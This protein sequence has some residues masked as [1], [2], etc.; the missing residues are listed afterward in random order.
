MDSNCCWRSF[1]VPPPTLRRSYPSDLALLVDVPLRSGVCVVA[2]GAPKAIPDRNFADI[3]PLLTRDF[4]GFQARAPR[5]ISAAVL[6]LLSGT[7]RRTLRDHVFPGVRP[8]RMIDADHFLNLPTFCA[9]DGGFI[10][11][12]VEFVTRFRVAAFPAF[13]CFADDRHCGVPSR[14]ACNFSIFFASGSASSR[15]PPPWKSPLRSH[16]AER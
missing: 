2:A 1:I 10:G 14:R 4:A 3:C 15:N 13:R 16:S 5:R 12:R 7:G 6:L 9:A 8:I 11:S